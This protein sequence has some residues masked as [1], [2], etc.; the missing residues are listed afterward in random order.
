MK[1][2]KKQALSP[3]QTAERN[4]G[5]DLL[6]LT[7][8]FL[9]VFLHTLSHG[10]VTTAQPMTPVYDIGFLLEALSYCCVNCFALASGYIGVEARFRHRNIISLWLQ[11]IFYTLC[12]TAVF[13]YVKSE[14]YVSDIIGDSP[15]KMAL[16][17]I[18]SNTYWY[19]TAYFA[20]FFFIPFL[21]AGL[22]K[23]T[24]RQAFTLVLSVIFIY[25]L[26]PSIAKNDLFLIGV[27]YNSTWIILLYVLGAA[28]RKLDIQKKIRK[29][30]CF[31]IFYAAFA[32]LAWYGKYY[33]EHRSFAED[34][35]QANNT[36]IQYTSLPILLSSISLLLFFGGIQISNSR[37]QSIIR[38][39]SAASFGVYLI[40][41][42]PLV[43]QLPFWNT[44]LGALGTKPISTMIP[45]VILYAVGIYTVCLGIDM[46]RGILFRLL[47][48]RNAVDF[49]CDK[50]NIQL[51]WMEEK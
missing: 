27:G 24:K 30:W 3:V 20:L 39:L 33:S 5:I 21:N 36:F 48:I 31:L 35:F 13:G 8:M 42:H 1:Q 15:L 10:A 25:I 22:S 49:I 4:Y 44:K 16:T 23:L 46:L 32:L 34:A 7:A 26:I 50:V 19:L 28:L 47:R 18:I 40:H 17:P 12:L 37:A 38:L 9:V 43:F 6:K 45:G 41:V 14:K 29:K 51:K 2:V 11:T